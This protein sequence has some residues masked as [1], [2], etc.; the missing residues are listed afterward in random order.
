MIYCFVLGGKTQKELL[1]FNTFS[2]PMEIWGCEDTRL[3]FL[4]RG[5]YIAWTVILPRVPFALLRTGQ[6][7]TGTT[8]TR[9]Q[10]ILFATLK[11]R[12]TAITPQA[13]ANGR[14]Y[15]GARQGS[16]GKGGLFVLA[17]LFRHFLVQ[18]RR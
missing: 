15:D 18:F 12:R 1:C 9:Q 11:Q 17:Q 5:Q 6:R 2:T 13:H 4:W 3:L 8:T 10:G 16:Q 14:Q 7:S